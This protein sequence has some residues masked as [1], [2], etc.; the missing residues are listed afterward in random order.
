MYRIK[1][2]NK[3]GTFKTGRTFRTKKS[4]QS[5]INQN[6]KADRE[7]NRGGYLNS[8]GKPVKITNKYKVV[9]SR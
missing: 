6:K 5:V 8:Q 2:S 3:S 1:V 4:A 9:K 7:L